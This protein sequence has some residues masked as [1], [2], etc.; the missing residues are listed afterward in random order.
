MSTHSRVINMLKLVLPLT[1]L[2]LL[3]T[4]F[5]FSRS[6]DPEAQIPFADVELTEKT[7]GQQITAPR[8]S[9]VTERG[10]VMTLSA[11]S[12]RPTGNTMSELDTLRAQI[13]LVS[14][15]VISFVAGEGEM[16]SARHLATLRGGVLIETS[17][18]YQVA[19]DALETYLR[20]LSARTEGAVSA[21][22][23]IGALEA[24]R[25]EIRPDKTS[26]DA[27]MVFTNGVRLVYSPGKS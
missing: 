6:A 26:E 13:D 5:L 21:Q 14:G 12:A 2:A 1:A 8:V 17:T 23:P 9:G 19:T 10:D 24:G 3:S 15:G 25:M 7:K 22:G 16:D 18:G 27:Y 11:Q 20:K 4:V